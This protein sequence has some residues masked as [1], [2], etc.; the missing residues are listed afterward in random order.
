MASTVGAAAFRAAGLGLAFGRG[1]GGGS[2]I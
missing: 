2:M 1:F